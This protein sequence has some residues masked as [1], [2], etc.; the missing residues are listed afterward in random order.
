MYLRLAFS[1]AAHLEPDIMVVDE[2]LAVG[3]SEFQSRCLRR[4]ETAEQEGRTVVFVS[5]NLDA[6]ARL[7]SRTIWLEGG[8]IAADGASGDV[9]EAYLSAQVERSTSTDLAADNTGPV[10]LNEVRIVDAS[11]RPAQVMRRENHFMIE[12]R[13]TV[14][15]PVPSLDLAAFILDARRG[16]ILSEAWSDTSPD[17]NCGV[18]KHV[19]RLKIPPILNVGDFTVGVWFGS[20]Y[21]TVLLEMTSARFR[22]EGDLKGRPKRSVALGLPWEVL[23]IEQEGRP[24]SSLPD[25]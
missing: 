11:G 4:M 21:E 16:E 15:E 22:L 14:R 19:A 5:H 12:V 8:R 6:I 25:D 18:G 10:G 9:V 17:R 3:D 1:V 24:S 13:F 2:V 20:A 23:R 7:C